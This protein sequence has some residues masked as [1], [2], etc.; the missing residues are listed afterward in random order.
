MAL[1]NLL[2][3]KSAKY[4]FVLSI[5]VAL[6]IISILRWA[7]LDSWGIKL[8]GITSDTDRLSSYIN[9]IGLT[10]FGTVS[11]ATSLF[12]FALKVN[13]DNLPDKLVARLS[14]DKVL[15]S[16]TLAMYCVAITLIIMSAYITKTFVSLPIF[17]TCLS[18]I[19]L[20]SYIFFSLK[21]VIKLIS[22]LFQLNRIFCETI[23]HL[24]HW[25]NR[26][27]EESGK[28]LLTEQ[29]NRLMEFYGADW[30]L[31]R[32]RYFELN[33]EMENRTSAE[34]ENIMT[35]I[36]RYDL[37]REYDV[38]VQA[39]DHLVDI[40]SEYIQIKGK[41]FTQAPSGDRVISNTIGSISMY[42]NQV[43]DDKNLFAIMLI[44]DT[45][46]RLIKVFLAIDYS[47]VNPIKTHVLIVATRL[48]QIAK[49]VSKNNMAEMEL[50]SLSYLGK[51]IIAMLDAGYTNQIEMLLEDIRNISTKGISN[52]DLRAF[53]D[54]GLSQ[55]SELSMKL[56]TV[57]SVDINPISSA[58]QDHLL[59]ITSALLEDEQTNES[60]SNINRAYLSNYFTLQSR[61]IVLSLWEI[62][63]KINEEPENCDHS[64]LRNV[65]RWSVGSQSK[66]KKILEEAVKFKSLFTRDLIF[67]IVNVAEALLLIS[68]RELHD[69]SKFDIQQQIQLQV[70][71]FFSMFQSLGGDEGSTLFLDQQELVDILFDVA[72]RA[73]TIDSL[74]T[75]RYVE[76]IMLTYCFNFALTSATTSAFIRGIC[77][78]SYLAIT[79]GNVGK[80]E[81][82]QQIELELNQQPENISEY[83]RV[84]IMIREIAETKQWPIIDGSYL[85]DAISS[86]NT[87]DLSEILSEI[88]DILER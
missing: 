20:P 55:Y 84:A 52:Y 54:E 74:S 40:N 19:L 80:S 46:V 5:L 72:R 88:A 67:W 7:D 33:L 31:Q 60:N 48:S 83:N 14:F 71:S 70:A 86:N 39:F 44:E 13:V 43:I 56:L 45:L 68:K 51:A 11:I 9:R 38:S 79:R 3:G 76:K 28:I 47:S 12:L 30:D 25:N 16:V 36:R 64:T 34:I 66:Y 17:V 10:L 63:S 69:D 32:L 73:R 81:L 2:N 77:S 50:R 24:K 78:C 85:A 22:P 53:I 82:K 18:L 42:S 27:N 61:G 59:S 26:A 58:I 35:F 4:S 37:K 21:R 75:S 41:T 57:T 6:V 29:D 87:E 8:Q 1:T 23:D 15:F 65:L 49:L 62:A